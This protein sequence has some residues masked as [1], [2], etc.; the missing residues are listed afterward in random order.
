MSPRTYSPGHAWL[1]QRALLALGAGLL[2]AL[3]T[4]Y[5]W[6]LAISG[7]LYVYLVR[8]AWSA[9]TDPAVW[10][11]PDL[12]GLA[13][14]YRRLA[15]A[16]VEVQRRVHQ[17]VRTAP[18]YLRESIRSIWLE[19]RPL[20]E[21]QLG[22]VRQLQGLGEC[23]LRLNPAQLHI[24]EADLVARR[25]RTA[26]PVA[27]Q[28]YDRALE[29]LRSRAGALRD[30]ETSAQRV[31]AQLQAVQQGLENAYSQVLQ[32]KTAGVGDDRDATELNAG[33]QSLSRQVTAL[34]EAVQQ[35]Y[36]RRTDEPW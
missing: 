4:G 25:K 2:T 11:E 15:E 36:A 21:Q 5:W 13:P 26:D 16:A 29:S 34:A 22:L 24:Q 8:M 30:L 1:D 35:V 3:A 28:Q 32:M 9:E 14:E 10:S 7:A 33:L 6:L 17:E 27:Q 31:E 23:L 19:I 18:P 12:R 20:G